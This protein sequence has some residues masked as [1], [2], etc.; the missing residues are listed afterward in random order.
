MA[1]LNDLG[2][3]QV[4]SSLVISSGFGH[5]CQFLICKFDEIFAYT[6]KRQAFLFVRGQKI[7]GSDWC[8]KKTTLR[9]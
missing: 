9:K 4:A 6:K 3:I 8:P 2:W 7:E 5:Q 1:K